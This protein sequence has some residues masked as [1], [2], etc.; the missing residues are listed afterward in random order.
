[1]GTAQ[2]EVMEHVM[3][4][5][6]L[7][8]MPKPR[9]GCERCGFLTIVHIWR[10]WP[11][12]SHA[13]L[14]SAWRLCGHVVWLRRGHNTRRRRAGRARFNHNSLEGFPAVLRDSERSKYPE[15]SRQSKQYPERAHIY[16]RVRRL[17]CSSPDPFSRFSSIFAVM[18]GRQKRRRLLAEN[19]PAWVV[20][21]FKPTKEEPRVLR[22]LVHLLAP[23][24]MYP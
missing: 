22:D 17:P 13:S 9:W 15:Y 11:C 14:H 20:D 8:V 12:M 7:V 16:Y 5:K 2:L 21:E 3:L 10:L 1:M 4:T 6:P 19:N 23:S 24:C 18:P